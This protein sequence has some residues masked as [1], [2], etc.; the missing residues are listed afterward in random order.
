M[1]DQQQRV[2]IAEACVK[3][4]ERDDLEFSSLEYR[5]MLKA[6]AD[7]AITACINDPNRPTDCVNWADLSVVDVLWCEGL[8]SEGEF[9][10]EI[11]EA[12]PDA[13]DLHRYLHK[14]IITHMLMN[15]E[16]QF[17]TQW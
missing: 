2:E 13:Y 12:S 5:Q 3:Y 6:C 16:I 14:Y 17:S 9:R 8:H 11:E 4:Y 10:I 15:P 1:T 7:D